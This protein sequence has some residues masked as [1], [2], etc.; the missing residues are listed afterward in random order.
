MKRRN[1][2]GI[3]VLTSSFLLVT[4]CGTPTFNDGPNQ[5]DEDKVLEVTFSEDFK[6]TYE[7]GEILRYTGITVKDSI[8]KEVIPYPMFSPNEGMGLNEPGEITITIRVDGYKDYTFKIT[9]VPSEDYVSKKRIDLYSVNDFHGSFI[10]NG[11]EVGMAR[12]ASF[13]KE[14]KEAGDVVLSAGDMWQGG[15]ES[16]L[17]KGKI[18]IDSMNY[19]GFD[20]MSVGNHEFD[21]GFET[22]ESNI[23]LMDFPMLGANA[24]DKRTNE[25]FDYFDPYT[26]VESKGIKIGIIGTGSEYLPDDITYEYAQYLD[27]KDQIPLIKSYSEELREEKDCDVIVLLAH[28]SGTYDYS[29]PEPVKYEELTETSSAN[30]LPY[31]DAIFLGHDH[32]T[33]SGIFNNI[34]YAEGGSNGENISH[35]S[36]NLV[37]SENGRYIVEEGSATTIDTSSYQPCKEEDEYILSLLD[38]YESELAPANEV[39]CTFSSYVSKDDF[40]ELLCLAMIEYV[41][42]PKNESVLIDDKKVNYGFH[43]NGGVRDSFSGGEFTY[44]DLI[45]VVPFDNTVCVAKLSLDQFNIWLDSSEHYEYSDISLEGDYVYIAAINYLSD[46]IASFPSLESKDTN[47]VIQD[48]LKEYLKAHDDEL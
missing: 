37:E 17:T 27:F 39:I 32:D 16:N 12:L 30:D 41:N 9:V 28:D 3:L 36:L 10:E 18:V 31:V 43:N 20:A 29:V 23:S 26:I 11:D 2:F 7:T 6:D 19:I 21:W 24:F 25:R 40:L 46:N 33:K 38:K 5:N 35:I 47:V 42:D 44:R 8:T 34:P 22:L 14:R 15:V 48:V 13:L 4:A 1:L 45:K